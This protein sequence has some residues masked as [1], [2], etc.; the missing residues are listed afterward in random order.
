MPT[1][2]SAAEM[3]H[4]TDPPCTETSNGLPFPMFVAF[5]VAGEAGA[6]FV[7]DGNVPLEPTP[8]ALQVAAGLVVCLLSSVEVIIAPVAMV[9]APMTI[10]MR[11]CS[12]FPSPFVVVSV[13]VLVIVLS[14][15]L[16]GALEV[17]GSRVECSA[18]R[19]VDQVADVAVAVAQPYALLS[20]SSGISS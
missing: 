9:L 16:L 8:P 14:S 12:V 18:L 15:P 2:T 4:C 20:I 10:G 3:S 5:A 17:L 6:S 7:C 13:T 19:V 11:T 1:P